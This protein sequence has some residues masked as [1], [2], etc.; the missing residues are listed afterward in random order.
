MADKITFDPAELDQMVHV[1]AN[2]DA[3]APEAPVDEGV[4]MIQLK[5]PKDMSQFAVPKKDKNNKLYLSFNVHGIIVDPG[6][7]FHERAVFPHTFTTPTTRLQERSETTTA[8]SLLKRLGMPVESDSV[9]HN[10]QKDM[11]WSAITARATI[12]A[13]V[14]W[15]LSKKEKDENGND[16]YTDVYTKQAEFPDDPN[17]PGQK[18]WQIPSDPLD[19]ASEKLTARAEIVEF[20]A[21]NG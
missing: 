13:R 17:K 20:I 21:I 12:K 1:D 6:G 5:G 19:P 2:A 4:Y 15:R 8:I 3:Y 11:L 14:K 16:K 18:L 9:S 10:Q 7:Q